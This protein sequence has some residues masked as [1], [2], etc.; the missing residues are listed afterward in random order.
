[1]VCWHR[2][3][4]VLSIILSIPLPAAAVHEPQSAMK[5]DWERHLDLPWQAVPDQAFRQAGQLVSERPGNGPVV[6]GYLPY[7]EFGDAV[8][9]LDLLTHVAYFGVS[10]DGQGRLQ[11]SRHWNTPA[12]DEVVAAARS[13]GVKVVLTIICFDSA[14]MDMLLNSEG[15][16]SNAISEITALVVAGDGDGV[17][18]DFE[19]LPKTAK[20]GFV[21]FVSDLKDSLD[22][23]LGDS[24]VTLA[25]PAVDWKGA[26]DYDRLAM[27]SD[28]L[29]LME[30]E[31]HYPGGSPGPISPLD[32]STT[33]G[34]Y[35]ITWSLDDYDTYGGT[36]NRHKFILGLPLYGHDWP[37]VGE[38]P[39]SQ[40]AGKADSIF[41]SAC[42]QQESRHGRNWDQDSAS[43]WYDY[44]DG[45]QYRQVWCDDSWSLALKMA[46]AR[47][48]GL[49]GIGF[50]ALGYEGSLDGPWQAVVDVFG[51]AGPDDLPDQVEDAADE[52]LAP[53][54]VEFVDVA[55]AQDSDLGPSQDSNDGD[56]AISE[57]VARDV[58]AVPR[59]EV[60]PMEDVAGDTGSLLL[61]DEVFETTDI[62]NT[63]SV[64][65]CNAGSR[66]ASLPGA[67]MVVVAV[68]IFLI[69]RPI[70]STR[71][72]RQ[73]RAAD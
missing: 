20:D 13:V 44:H 36:K 29:F 5:R 63:D 46:P 40:S 2:L 38:T 3:L 19:G 37:A 39:P 9:H 21:Q 32:G 11:D 18:L 42:R 55:D 4:L 51:L 70:L 17:N 45:Q 57:D 69:A 15:Y 27:A 24:S 16:R 60:G 71:R 50:W 30:Y 1:M 68:L 48:R 66:P 59:S 7:W 23:S 54:I 73:G 22:A 52:S 58:D 33:W 56:F 62:I 28:G 72:H 47:D 25:M 53:E 6:F 41:F 14:A 8:L 49:G 35:S 64:A 10:I 67:V 43:P 61:P 31:F 26:Y 34:K 12:M 65:S